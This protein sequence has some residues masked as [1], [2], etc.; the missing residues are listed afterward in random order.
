MAA[1]GSGEI[2]REVMDRD[3]RKLRCD[4]RRTARH[5]V[6]DAQVLGALHGVRED[7]RRVAVAIERDLRQRVVLRLERRSKDG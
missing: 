7:D 1:R 3:P 2:E 5:D 6:R 4:H